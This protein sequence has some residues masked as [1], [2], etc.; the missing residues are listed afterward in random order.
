MRTDKSSIRRMFTVLIVMGMVLSVGRVRAE[1]E[2][3]PMPAASE[4][5]VWQAEDAHLRGQWTRVEHPWASGGAYVKPEKLEQGTMLEF[6]FRTESFTTLRV[7]PVWWKHGERKPAKRF[8]YPLE[9]LPG[10]DVVDWYDRFAFFTAPANGRIGL[11]DMES[12]SLLKAIEVGGY[13]ADLVAD[14]NLGKVYVADAK[15]NL[16]IV[17]DAEKHVKLKEIEVPDCP[18]SLALGDGK[19]YVACKTGKSLTVIDTAEDQVSNQVALPEAP[20]RVEVV[21]D[22][23]QRVIVWP[24]VRIFDRNTLE[25]MAPEAETYV[26]RNHAI[27]DF[28]EYW[29]TRAL[30]GLRIYSASKPHVLNVRHTETGEAK[31][32]DV[33]SVTGSEKVAKEFPTPLEDNPGPGNMAL[34]DKFIFFTSP[35]TGKIGV[36]D[37]IEDVLVDEIYMGG[38][39]VDVV[40]DGSRVYVADAM[41]NRVVVLDAR[42]RKVIKTVEVPV[43]PW[44]LCYQDGKLFVACGGGKEVVSIDTEKDYA[45]SRRISFSTEPLRVQI[46]LPPANFWWPLLSSD[47]VPLVRRT[48]L[49]V[50]FAPMAFDPSSLKMIEPNGV[51]EDPPD[52]RRS[53]AWKSSKG[54]VE[55]KILVDNELTIGINEKWIDVS[56]VADYQL[57]PGAQ[58]LAADDQQGT[59]SLSMDTG[60]EY[61]WRRGVWITPDQR[62]FLVNETDEF[63]R[64]NAPLFSVPPGQHTLRAHVHSQ[65]A[66]IDGLKISRVLEGH[67]EMGVSPHESH[68]IFY[69]DEPVRFSLNVRN[70]LDKP[71]RVTLVRDVSNYMDEVVYSDEIELTLRPE[72]TWDKSLELGL[73][74]TGRFTLTMAVRSEDGQMKRSYRFLRLP[75]LEHPRLL[76]RKDDIPQIKAR[77]KEYPNLFGRYVSWLRRMCERDGERL[78]ER[79]LPAGLTRQE[80]AEAAPPEGEGIY[81][82]GM[83]ELGWRMLS[84]QFASMFLEYPGFVSDNTSDEDFFESKLAYLLEAERADGSCQFHGGGLFFQGAAASLFDMAAMDSEKGKRKI[85]KMFGTY[86]GNMDVFSWTLVTLEEPLT[87]EDR[88][89]LSE[90]MILEDNAERYFTAHC[91][92]RGG[93]WWLNPWT[94]CHCP[95]DGYMLMFVYCRNFFGEERLFEK[96]FFSGFHTFHRYV[97][98]LQPRTR[99]LPH[100]HGPQSEPASWLETVL[101]DMPLK[102]RNYGWDLWTWKLNSDMD[103]SEPEVDKLFDLEGMPI[104][105]PL[106]AEINHFVTG[107]SVPLALALGWY[108]PGSPEVDWQE[109]PPTVLFDVEGWVPM[110][111]GW[112]RNATEVSFISGARDHTYRH[113]PNHFHI[114]KSGEWLIGIGALMYDHGDPVNSW[115]NVVVAGTDWLGIWKENL[116]HPRA[117]EYFI[118]NRFSDPTWRYI[119]RDS[120]LTGYAPAEGGWGGGLDLHGHT[121]SAFVKEAEIVAYETWPEF[122]YVAG[123]A[124]NSWPVEKVAEMYRQLV[125][126]KPDVVVIHDRVVTGPEGEKTRWLAATG[127]TLTTGGNSFFVRRGSALLYGEVL[128]PE[129]FTFSIQSSP[130][131]AYRVHELV[132]ADQKALEVIPSDQNREVEYLV[133]MNVG[134]EGIAPLS[135]KLVRKDGYVGVAFAY[136]EE[137]VEL[138]FRRN[139]VVGGHITIAGRDR[140]IDHEFTQEVNDSYLHWMD[141]PRFEDWMTQPR[142]QFLHME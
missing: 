71:Q 33:R 79:F 102:K 74:D 106:M 111:S 3:F 81:D 85:Q 22:D 109:L 95:L 103:L 80:L 61:N 133:V 4:E 68:W 131:R 67:V 136:N 112:D 40:A 38:Y 83:T 6:P 59:I 88:A 53:I 132:W 97:D 9:L 104:K 84:C 63:W 45:V 126:I 121:E 77:I 56:S 92:K 42:E 14:R 21:K 43:L 99:L 135:P 15:N 26:F 41:G 8:P 12:E 141:D 47:R 93:S 66:Q 30:L 116:W 72:E 82:A 51:S 60:Q 86:R 1:G 117:D 55:K 110:R 108:K 39:P 49:A 46:V 119:T 128:L 69:Y 24:V 115:G 44:S 113:R 120:R 32:V 28:T 25:E 57:I 70:L 31:T 54:D 52:R 125:F 91:G 34:Y 16:V 23:V 124:T 19:L 58:P 17:L 96:D 122:D 101:S 129:K 27:A 87:E 142:F 114:I 13:L 78:P 123:D 139:G 130:A 98:P 10:P 94:M 50:K 76:F 127:P 105:G 73:K 62:L 35:A 134:N 75:K 65:F 100:I 140:V 137:S 37:A 5:A 48:P 2:Y 7:Y 138:L 64:W 29:Y 90:I 36:V 20:M 18:W 118:I 89:L 107:V 11:L